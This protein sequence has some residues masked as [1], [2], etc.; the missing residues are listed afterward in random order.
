MHD[1]N[2]GV[3]IVIL[4]AEDPRDMARLKI[5]KTNAALEAAVKEKTNHFLHQ[6]DQVIFYIIFFFSITCLKDVMFPC[7]HP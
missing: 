4:G 7:V 1:T 2:Q 5:Q 3:L 6:K